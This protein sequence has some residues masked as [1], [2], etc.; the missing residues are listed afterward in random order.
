[1]FSLFFLSF[2]L[3]MQR[4][5]VSKCSA[6][7]CFG[8]VL[9]LLQKGRPGECGSNVLET[10]KKVHTQRPVPPFAWF[11]LALI[12]FYSMWF[13]IGELESKKED[14][15]YGRAVEGNSYTQE[16]K[17]VSF[18]PYKDKTLADVEGNDKQSDGKCVWGVCGAPLGRCSVCGGFGWHHLSPL[19]SAGCGM[20]QHFDGA[21]SEPSA[22]ICIHKCLL[23]YAQEGINK[24]LLLSVNERSTQT[25]AA[26]L[27]IDPTEG[28]C[29]LF[30]WTSLLRSGLCVTQCEG[31]AAGFVLL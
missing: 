21:A 3:V 27:K 30:K 14:I 19:C 9:P 24:N 29:S 13:F 22:F 26:A 6:V 25:R 28:H 18:S 23:C 11:V 20:C 31:T 7:W 15:R 4:P 5:N 17:F 16:M 10:E 8:F 1:M 12:P 2:F